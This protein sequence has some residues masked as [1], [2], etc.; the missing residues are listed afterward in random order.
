MR[1]K[2]EKLNYIKSIKKYQIGDKIKQYRNSHPILDFIAGFIPYVGEAQDAQDFYNA[3]KKNDYVGMGL[4][5]LGLIIPGLTGGQITKGLKASKKVAN[6]IKALE[7]SDIKNIA[8]LEDNSVAIKKIMDEPLPEGWREKGWS[9]AKDGAFVSKDGRRFIRYDGK[10]RPENQIDE[11]KQIANREAK[12]KSS[13]KIAQKLAKEKKKIFDNAV[14]QF[15]Q[16]SKG[17][18]FSLEH[19]QSLASGHKMTD[20]EKQLYMIEAFPNFVRSYRNLTKVGEERLKK[21]GNKW[22]GWFDEPV[23][24]NISDN[25][26]VLKQKWNKGWRELN[27][28]TGAMTYVIMNSEQ[29]KGKFLYNGITMRQGIPE[30]K[31]DI[32]ARRNFEKGSQNFE[33]WFD[34]DISG[35]PEY[36][37]PDNTKGGMMIYG[38]PIKPSFLFPG[39]SDSPRLIKRLSA[40]PTS[41]NWNG[42]GDPIGAF[43][44]RNSEK[45][46][47]I[48]EGP[49]IDS[50]ASRSQGHTVKGIFTI[51]GRDI[52]VKSIFGGSGMYDT[53][54]HLYE[55]FR[56]LAMPIGLTSLIGYKAY[57]KTKE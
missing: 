51:V 46:I 53:E 7:K 40:N 33:K 4:A 27:G 29:A 2:N 39:T 14:E 42:A 28:E 43:L 52:P 54:K 50:A 5:S 11:I 22:Y 21:I 23:V 37:H 12:R 15:K 48:S 26:P 25:L 57:D 32:P 18:D 31:G 19:W 16:E 30:L 35:A 49:L 10:L 17:L 1:N 47:H 9:I 8:K 45:A 56:Q 13:E 24:N 6:K 55:P 34:S 44:D 36:A 41:T 3:S 38:I 20:I